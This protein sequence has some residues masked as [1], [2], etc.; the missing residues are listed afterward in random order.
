MGRVKR[1][2]QFRLAQYLGVFM[3]ILT[4]GAAVRNIAGEVV[5]GIFVV[6]SFVVFIR[7]KSN[8]WCV[9][10][11]NLLVF[12]ILFIS[13]VFNYLI[14]IQYSPSIGAYIA[15]ILSIVGTFFLAEGL[16]FKDFQ[17]LYVNTMTALSTASL[18]LY[19][20]AYVLPL[21]SYVYISP[22]SSTARLFFLHNFYAFDKGRNCGI[23]NEPGLYAVFLCIAILFVLQDEYRNSRQKGILLLL[24]S[25]S[26]I[27]TVS[28]TGYIVLAIEMVPIFKKIMDSQK[29]IKLKVLVSLLVVPIVI[30]LFLKL[31]YSDAFYTKVVLGKGSFGTRINDLMNSFVILRKYFNLGTGINT[32]V[33]INEYNYYG[34][35]NNS[36][37]LLV[38]MIY[39]GAWYGLFY[40]ITASVRT[41]RQMKNPVLIL[42]I[43]FVFSL[44]QSILQYPICFMFLFY[45]KSVNGEKSRITSKGLT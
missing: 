25:I 37:G 24:F 9:K 6:T 45:F 21:S 34:H 18:L 8:W 5:C 29:N 16:S 10:T 42:V 40:M 20:L 23:F 28:T 30:F 39:M 44:S 11:S 12:C 19:S 14:H 1:K 17:S 7:Y 41:F 33:M 4:S 36:V 35:V 38:T 13:F 3:L 32:T 27:T 2:K 22:A 31:Y 43:M 26:V 15:F